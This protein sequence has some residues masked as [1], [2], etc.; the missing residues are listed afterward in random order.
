MRGDANEQPDAE[1]YTV[2]EAQRVVFVVPKAGY[3]VAWST[4]PVGLVL[5][6]GYG[7]FLLSVLLRRKDRDDDPAGRARR[8]RSGKAA[9]RPT[10][11]SG[12]AR[13]C[14]RGS[15][16][17]RADPCLGCAMDRPGDRHRH[18]VYGLHRA[19]AGI[20]SCT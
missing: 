3:V 5:L 16:R 10:G 13:R 2:T 17:C 1:V 8:A 11:C 12:V 9:C 18:Y 14:A 6:G 19:Q 15:D 7:A 4:G 20:V